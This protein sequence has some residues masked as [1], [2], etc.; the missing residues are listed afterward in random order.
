LL[1][2]VNL[3]REIY[4]AAGTITFALFVHLLAFH[5]CPG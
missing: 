1:V 2:S 3:Q 4:Q 5:F